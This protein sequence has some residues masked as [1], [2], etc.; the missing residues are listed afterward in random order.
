MDG[1]SHH[2]TTT[3]LR[4]Q[5]G[6]LFIHVKLI[7]K[8]KHIAKHISGISLAYLWHIFDRTPENYVFLTA[9]QLLYGVE[10]LIASL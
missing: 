4:P 7:F 10:W 8:K 5:Y 3:A 1:L 9:N 6:H 2:N